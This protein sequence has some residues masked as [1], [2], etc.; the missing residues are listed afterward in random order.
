[1]QKTSLKMRIEKI[2]NKISLNYRISCL[3]I[4]IF[5]FSIYIF[6]ST[7][8]L[9]LHFDFI[10]L[11]VISGISILIGFQFFGIKYFSYEIKSKLL[12]LKPNFKEDHHSIYLEFLEEKFQK[13]K[14]YYLVL[15]L[16]V[17]PFIL[18]TILGLLSGSL[19]FSDVESS[20]NWAIPFD[21]FNTTIYFLSLFLFAKIVW[22]MINLNI[23]VHELNEN[24]YINI[25]IFNI[26]L[27]GLNSMRGI[28]MRFITYYFIITTLLMFSYG[29]SPYII[30]SYES[31]FLYIVT[32]LGIILFISTKKTI[33]N[34]VNK[35]L[36]IELNRINEENK[37]IHNN[38]LS[39]S[40]DKFNKEG[41]EKLS[42]SLDLLEREEI[43]IK[44]L[45]HKKFNFIELGKFISSFLIA[46]ATFI[47][48]VLDNA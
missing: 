45:L 35:H 15:L 27:T 44:Q 7:K 16:I 5:I 10:T 29:F 23:V 22:I 21:I 25:D 34:L 47:K 38:I 12:G 33:K 11:F 28:I 6:F 26:D 4:T 40:T 31:V 9:F 17:F 24:P 20:N 30:L 48:I 14:K 3:F 46:T 37:K 13:S 39:I 36:K 19:L 42:I 18:I 41:L 8:L 43:K 1:M 32:F 2:L